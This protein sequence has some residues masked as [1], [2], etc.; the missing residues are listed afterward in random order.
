MRRKQI[1]L[2]ALCDRVGK[3]ISKAKMILFSLHSKK[4]PAE[5]ATDYEIHPESMLYRLCDWIGNMTG[6]IILTPH[7]VAVGNCAE[8]VYFGLLKAR[9]EGKK[10]VIL[11]PYELPWRLK[12]R[13]TNVEVVNVDSEYRAISF[14][15]LPCI[16]GRALITVYFAFFRTLSLARRLLFGVH[17]NN[18][19]RIPTIG[20]STLWQPKEVTSFSWDVVNQFG[21]PKQ[22]ENPLK[23]F[24]GEKKQSLAIRQRSQMGLPEDAWF[25]CLHVRQ[26]GFRDSESYKESDRY[27]ERNANIFN[28]INAI[29]EITRRGGWVVR[30]GD[31]SMTKLPAMERVIDYPFTK[32]KCALMDVYLISQCRLYIG[33]S[34]GIYDVARL[35]Q[36]PMIMT[37]MNNWLMTF[38]IKNGDLGVTK[39]I[40]SKSRNRFLSLSEWLLEPWKGVSFSHEL[41]DDYVF[42]ENTSDELRA[43]VKEFF[44]RGNDW[45]PSP[46]QLQFNAARVM[47]GRE[48]LSDRLFYSD[49][50]QPYYRKNVVDYD[51]VERYR[52][53]SRLDSAVGMLGTEFLQ[54][55]WDTTAE[56]NAGN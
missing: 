35:F 11:W 51:L 8:D 5:L 39:R 19:Y 42:H 17:L 47:R 1:V 24:L 18:V 56:R 41:G 29:E 9:R 37:N 27:D 15:S 33:M 10:L 6:T 30:M 2:Y 7:L 46:L 26:S 22:L 23:V 54:Q 14:D 52:L 28:Y 45:K 48:I 38:P 49:N 34:S 36:R 16:V 25:V 21:W 4:A 44:D 55:N 32:E 40:F 20:A 31:A 3:T 13:L 12:F 50:V 53:A 43:V